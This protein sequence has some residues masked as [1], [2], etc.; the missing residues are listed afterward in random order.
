MQHAGTFVSAFRA[1]SAAPACWE[2]RCCSV[3]LL[4]APVHSCVLLCVCGPNHM[5]PSLHPHV[6]CGHPCVLLVLPPTAVLQRLV[7]SCVCA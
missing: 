6:L 2:H 4:R 1:A 5:P 7:V 3:Q